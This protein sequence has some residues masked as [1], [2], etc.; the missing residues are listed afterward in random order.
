M[1]ISVASGKGG[2]GKTLV[3]TNLALSL[4][5]IGKVQLLDCDVEE[6]NGHLFLKPKI[7]TEEDV[8]VL[9]PSKVDKKRCKQCKTV[10]RVISGTQ[11]KQQKPFDQITKCDDLLPTGR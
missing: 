3:A 8:T 9:S 7:K 11:L 5:D 2:T 4:N 1:I 10:S 6:P